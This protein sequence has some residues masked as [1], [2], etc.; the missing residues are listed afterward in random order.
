MWSDMYRSGILLVALCFAASGQ[1]PAVE[2]ETAPRVETANHQTGEV[3]NPGPE[4]IIA[5]YRASAET[6][7]FRDESDPDKGVYVYLDEATELLYR[8]SIHQFGT[9][10]LPEV[11]MLSKRENEDGYLVIESTIHASELIWVEAVSVLSEARAE[12]VTATETRINE[13]HE[14]FAKALEEQ[15]AH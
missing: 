9:S 5:A 7:G 13:L 10:F 6:F 11:G 12:Q 1:E 15:R 8:L 2:G 14:A 3:E 4:E